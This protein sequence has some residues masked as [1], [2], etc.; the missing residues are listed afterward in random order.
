MLWGVGVSFYVQKDTPTP[1]GGI[2]FAFVPRGRCDFPVGHMVDLTPNGQGG[3]WG[4]VEA[5]GR[6]RK[7]AMA[8]YTEGRGGAE[9]G[10]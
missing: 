8:R 10:I 2:P 6:A 1:H 5:M 7:L 3:C 4:V 9:T